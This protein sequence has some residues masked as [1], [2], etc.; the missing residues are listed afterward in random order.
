MSF[1]YKVSGYNRKRKWALFE[2]LIR[3]TADLTVLDVGFNE[4]EHSSTDN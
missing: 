1:A 2:R 4:I 3:P